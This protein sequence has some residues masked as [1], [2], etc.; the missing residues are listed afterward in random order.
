MKVELA[1]GI[2]S[3]SGKC[4]NMIFKTYKRPNGKTE[5]R[6]Y[7]NPYRRSRWGKVNPRKTPLSEAEIKARSLFARDTDVGDMEFV[8]GELGAGKDEASMAIRRDDAAL[9]SLA[10]E[11]V[12]AMLNMVAERRI[13][14]PCERFTLS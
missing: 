9:V 6:A 4:G 11:A 1:A 8:L 7:F 13:E 5:T 2:E 3:V 14:H 12:F 10:E